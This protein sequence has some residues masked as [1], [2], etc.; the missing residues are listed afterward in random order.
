LFHWF[1]KMQKSVSLSSAEAEY[2]GAM[3]AARDLIFV[4]D[5]LIELAHLHDIGRK[6]SRS[7]VHLRV[8]HGVSFIREDQGLLWA[9]KQTKL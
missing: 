8:S 4:R 5:L 2:F 1:S 9:V 7:Y 6:G 3:M